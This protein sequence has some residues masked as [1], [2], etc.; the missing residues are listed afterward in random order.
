M[1]TI[2]IILQ[3]IFKEK[4]QNFFLFHA[5][6]KTISYFDNTNTLEIM[7]KPFMYVYV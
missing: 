6:Y 5:I 4:Y 7:L 3:K 2:K 1:I